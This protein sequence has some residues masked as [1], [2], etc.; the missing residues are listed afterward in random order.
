MSQIIT[1]YFIHK[2]EIDD[3]QQQGD[4]FKKAQS[5]FSIDPETFKSVET[6]LTARDRSILRVRGKLISTIQN[7]IYPCCTKCHRLTTAE[8][9]CLFE[10]HS[11]HEIKNAIPRYRF[12]LLIYDPTGDMEVTIFGDEGEKIMQMLGTDFLDKYSNARLLTIDS[13]NSNLHQ[14]QLK[15]KVHS[16]NFNKQD[17]TST[18][19][20]TVQSLECHQLPPST[21]NTNQLPCSPI[22]THDIPAASSPGMQEMLKSQNYHNQTQD[23]SYHQRKTILALT[24]TPPHPPVAEH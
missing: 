11:C 15:M 7:F 24:Y 14:L 22:S 19:S 9:G 12:S 1:M 20:H 2:R 6:F 18:L 4:V 21:I 5:N 10:C 17:G 13:I 16:K 23:L 8:Y 3:I